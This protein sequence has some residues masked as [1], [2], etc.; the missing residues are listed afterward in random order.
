[1]NNFIICNTREFVKNK[2][3]TTK[4]IEDC[5]RLLCKK[6]KTL[7]LG[8][9]R[10]LCSECLAIPTLDP[11]EVRQRD[12][13][14]V[15][16]SISTANLFSYRP[17]IHPEYKRLI[18]SPPPARDRSVSS[19]PMSFLGKEPICMTPSPTSF[20][21]SESPFSSPCPSPSLSPSESSPSIMEGRRR[22]HHKSSRPS[23]PDFRPSRF[24]NRKPEKI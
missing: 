21:S 12:A 16:G 19:S 11:V 14:P 10:L 2:H 3:I 13:L 4:D 17:D 1:M 15:S 7:S 5:I 18:V 9:L 22:Q 23:T 20:L 24:T 8:L 6:D